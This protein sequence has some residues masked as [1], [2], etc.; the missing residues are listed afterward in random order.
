MG[1]KNTHLGELL[2]ILI[3]YDPDNN[4]VESMDEI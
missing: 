1:A 4:S 3:D 2:K